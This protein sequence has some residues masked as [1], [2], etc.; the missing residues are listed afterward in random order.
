[1]REIPLTRGLRALV[2]DEDY[3]IVSAVGK[4]QAIESRGGFYA[5]HNTRG[6]RTYMHRLLLPGAELVDH[7]NG[8]GL[9]NRRSNLRPADHSRNSMNSRAKKTGSSRY[10][11]VAAH[12]SLTNPWRAQIKVAGKALA[13]GAFSSQI[14]AARAY[15]IAAVQY[16]GEF[17]RLNFPQE[18]S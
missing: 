12:R 13:L 17:A 5:A 15:D 16:F 7:I 2:D 3:T 9:D 10:K 6:P 4:W 1:M 18:G 11:G 14:D 8:D